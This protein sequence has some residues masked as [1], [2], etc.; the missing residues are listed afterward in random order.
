MTVPG[1]EAISVEALRVF[2]G[3]NV[4]L[5]PIDFHVREGGMLVIIGETG[6][7][8]SLAVQAIL[9]TLHGSLRAEGR[10]T[11]N[12]Q[13]LDTLAPG[14]RAALWG[15][16]LATLP[17]EPWRSL[18]PLMR[19]RPQVHEAHRFVSCLPRR[20]A[21]IATDRTFGSLGLHGAER[22]LPGALSGG[23]AQRVAFAAA[24]AAGAP[25]LLADEP[26]KGLDT[27]R[28]AAVVSLLAQV[29]QAGGALVVI[30]HDIAVARRLGGEALI[31]KEGR[32][33]ERGPTRTV[34]VSPTTPYTKALL[35][36]D[37]ACWQRTRP[38]RFDESVLMADS[39]GIARGGRVL[40]DDFSLRLHAG[41]RVAITGPSGV[42]KTTLLDTLAGL[43]MPARGTIRRAA[44]LAPTGMQK[45][46]QDPPAAFPARVRLSCSLRDVARIHGV[47]WA[48]VTDILSRLGVHPSL[49]DRRPG[50]VSGGEL[51]RISIARALTVRPGILLADEPTS[52]LDPITQ[53][54]TMNLLANIANE[55]RIAMVLV[56]HD[57]A[58]AEAWANRRI[59]LNAPQVPAFPDSGSNPATDPI[60]S[61]RESA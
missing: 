47:A 8:K 57:N 40:I 5:G 21:G 30:T 1:Q 14:A 3:Q 26:T 19:S 45:L 43:L 28:H 29:P 61:G 52:R 51:Q 31:L 27:V 11:V 37:P 42:G 12:G 60:M 34:L 9:G 16:K 25:I 44:R 54:D 6:A 58:I 7:G 35:E 59:A 49:L 24:T 36:A 32:M 48:L 17:Q 50:E 15:R 20:S 18:D 23:M 33:V 39:L 2:T 53:R 56:T 22:Y 13:R 46:Y 38:H 55:E 41:E 4:L 10:I